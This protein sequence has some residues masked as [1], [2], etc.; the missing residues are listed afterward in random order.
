M[1]F[2]TALRRACV[3]V[4]LLAFWQV[5]AS[6]DV[7]DERLYS[8]PERI[9]D[10]FVELTRDGTLQDNVGVS[11]LRA[12]AGLALGAG[13]GLLVGLAAGLW[14]LAEET[15]D[16]TI[17]IVR[18]VPVFALTG[19]FIVWFGIGETPR[20]VLIASACFFPMYLNVYSGVRG[21]DRKLLEMSD[22]MEVGSLS[23]MRHVLLPGALPSALVGLRFALAYSVLALVIAETINSRNGIGYLLS[24]A[25]QYLQTDIIFT[26]VLL[27]GVL[28]VVSDV[29][30]RILERVLLGWRAGVEAR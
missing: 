5:L 25:Q 11:L 19:L 20:I 14:R 30:V 29:L 6:T 27:Y 7:I 1:R 22:S 23:A 8:S 10:T 16:L 28:G 3:P 18:T 24:S 15:V 26:C 4:L 2:A 12:L 17:Q 9:A 21:V 13:L